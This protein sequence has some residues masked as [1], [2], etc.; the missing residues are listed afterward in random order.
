M[1]IEV[2][3]IH[4]EVT[5][6]SSSE[7]ATNATITGASPSVGAVSVG[8]GAR[9]Y[10]IIEEDVTLTT[11]IGE[12]NGWVQSGTET[13]DFGWD[14]DIQTFMNALVT[15]R[16]IP[17][18]LNATLVEI[19]ETYIN[20]ITEITVPTIVNESSRINEEYSF[21]GVLGGNVWSALNDLCAI[22]K[23]EIVYRGDSL[24]IRDMG[25]YIVPADV[26]VAPYTIN[27]NVGNT[28]RKIETV[29]TNQRVI[30]SGKP[31]IENLSTNPSLES[32]TTGWS[33]TTTSNPDLTRTDSRTTTWASS[34]TYS[35]NVKDVITTTPTADTITITH[36][37][38]TIEAGKPLFISC[39]IKP[40]TGLTATVTAKLRNSSNTVI[41]TIQKTNQPAGTVTLYTANVVAG[42]TNV[43]IEVQSGYSI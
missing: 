15:A 26:D 5:G 2:D 41:Q 6:W 9:E 14:I 31:Y 42:V 20:L 16:D 39:A 29:Y 36:D 21:H 22:T 18:V 23:T 37:A 17:T 43:V 8:L 7:S 33:Y 40:S 10:S 3:T 11:P 34:G 38:T 13:P 27:W 1:V 35:Y 24:V 4:D 30:A 32:D 12:Y 19:I 28:G 25:S